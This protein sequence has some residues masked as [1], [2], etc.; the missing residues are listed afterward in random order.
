MKPNR[1]YLLVISLIILFSLE[2]PS[3][4]ARPNL[5]TAGTAFTYQGELVYQGA[6]VNGSF[7][8]KFSLYNALTG[9]ISWAPRMMWPCISRSIMKM[10]FA[11]TQM[12]PAPIL[13]AVTTATL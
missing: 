6:L 11:S 10:P 5:A 1:I 2:V 3:A 9:P 13:L 4:A 8:F 7:D 12:P